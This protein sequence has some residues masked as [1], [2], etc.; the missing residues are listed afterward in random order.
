MTDLPHEYTADGDFISDLTGCAR[1]HGEGHKDVHWRKLT[2][3]YVEDSGTAM[4]HWAPCPTN[5][6]PILMCKVPETSTLA[7]R[8]PPPCV[9]CGDQTSLF[10]LGVPWHPRCYEAVRLVREAK[11]QVVDLAQEH[12]DA[13]RYIEEG[14]LQVPDAALYPTRYKFGDLS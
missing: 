6:E 8:Q 12:L 7:P 3:P 1:C 4:T 9:L 2:F 10:V 14:G 13:F 11:Q 5:G